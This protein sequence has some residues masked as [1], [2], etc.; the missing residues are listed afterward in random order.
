MT[1]AYIWMTVKHPILKTAQESAVALRI[2]ESKR[3]K[4]N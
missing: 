3:T 1:A 4:H 2:T